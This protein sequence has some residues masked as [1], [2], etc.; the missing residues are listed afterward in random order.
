MH[1]MPG[2]RVHLLLVRSVRLQ[3]AQG[4]HIKEFYY[5][6]FAGRQEPVP[7]PIP[8]YIKD[9]ILVSMSSVR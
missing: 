9:I 2:H 7:V 3:F 6:I 8:F 1:R 4:A 5:L